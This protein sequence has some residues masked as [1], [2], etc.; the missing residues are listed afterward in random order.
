MTRTTKNHEFSSTQHGYLNENPNHIK[1]NGAG[2]GNWG[3]IE[4]E[5][6]M[7]TNSA[8]KRRGSSN[9]NSNVPVE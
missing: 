4:D 9:S 7:Y 8:N 1:K 2:K 5:I 3:S 6:K